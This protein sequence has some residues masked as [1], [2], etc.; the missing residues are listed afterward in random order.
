MAVAL[1]SARLTPPPPERAVCAEDCSR[2]YLPHTFTQRYWRRVTDSRPEASTAG[3][4]NHGP[5]VL[6]LPS[7]AVDSWKP[8]RMVNVQYRRGGRAP[9][10]SQA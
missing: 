5:V 7:I 3:D 8:W 2:R 6:G 1:R 10:A 4:F 9:R